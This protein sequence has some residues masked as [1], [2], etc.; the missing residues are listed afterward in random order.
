MIVY[1]YVIMEHHLHCIAS[2]EELSKTMKEF[3]SYM[4]RRIIDYLKDRNSIYLLEKLKTAKLSHKTESKYQLWQ[5][6]SHPEE[7]YNEKM[8]LQK[9]DYNHNNP[10]R[11]GYV[12][13]PKH[14]R[15]SSARNY[16][17]MEGLIAVRT[18]WRN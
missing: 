8:L 17:G 15:Y 6:G 18:D 5:E 11:R 7:I 1:A 10:V 9:I 2:A 13:E 16:E 3:K 12:D 4:A 14:W